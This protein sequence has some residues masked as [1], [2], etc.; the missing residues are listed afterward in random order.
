MTDLIQTETNDPSP[1]TNGEPEHNTNGPWCWCA[2][3]RRIETDADGE[4]VEILIHRDIA[5]IV[6]E[7]H[8]TVIIAQQCEL[9]AALVKIKAMDGA[10]TRHHFDEDTWKMLV[11]EELE[12]MNK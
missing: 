7:A 12:L 10:A 5:Q 1:W 4:L 11:S 6:R 9:T 2:P 3:Y 8:N